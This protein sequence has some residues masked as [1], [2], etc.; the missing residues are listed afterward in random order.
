MNHNMIKYKHALALNPYFGDSTAF[1]GVFPPTGLEYIAASMKDLVGKVTLLDLR[2]EKAYQDPKALSKFIRN[3]I[4][5]LCVSIRWESQF[6][7]ICDFV[8]QLP[9]EICTVV[10]G[11]K[12][13]EEVKE[14]FDRCP[15]I[16]MVVR[17]EGEDI[18]K[19]IVTGVPYK[20]IR[21][22]SY[23]ENG[24]IVHNEIHTLPDITKIP[25]PDR[26]LRKHDYRMVKGGVQ[27]SNH[28]FDT[29]LTTR[30]CPFKCKF[31]TFSLN[32][33]GQKRG[34]TE[35]SVDSVI[36]ELKTVT[37]DV[38]LF[39]DDN[40]FTN[41]KRSEQLCD[42][43]IENK[44]KK[45][46][47]VQARVDVARHPSILDKAEKAGFK[48]F[49][50]GIESPHDR[51]LKQLEKGI[52]QQEIRDAFAVLTQHDFYLHGYFIYGNIGETE[53][54][55]L[56]IPK[57][58]KEIK[59]DSINFH[60]LRIEK[61]S[62]LKEV[63]EETPGYYYNRIGGSVYSER[64]GRK[65]LM[66]IRNRIRSEFYDLPQVIRIIRKAKSIGLVSGRDLTDGFF[67]LPL[68]MYGLARRKTRNR[69]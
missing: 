33:L 40:F 62:V 60:K 34:Y 18:I 68:L 30:G 52:T 5:L 17:G 11:Y 39:S 14:L 44:I 3:E 38:V 6:E 29:T 16:D 12:A 65:E 69:I 26:S 13:T 31:C 36:E 43:I 15:N 20:D 59:L 57:F 25:F 9:P 51:I 61:F 53:E 56:Y 10:G 27:I 41:P 37:A 66:Q 21:G 8:S 4:D 67:K 55:M 32:P 24:R 35:R 58:A 50:F 1:I 22:L 42:L 49:L 54:E 47:A 23:R 64:Y 2:Y 48:V 63:V 7:S 28:T 46:F 19:Q 45:I